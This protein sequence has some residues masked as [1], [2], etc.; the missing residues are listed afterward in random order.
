MFF[1]HFVTKSCIKEGKDVIF[2]KQ[3][4]RNT[5]Q[6]VSRDIFD[7]FEHFLPGERYIMIEHGFAHRKHVIFLILGRDSH[8]T[9]E[10]L[11]RALELQTA[12]FLVSKAFELFG[13]QIQTLIK[14]IGF[15]REVDIP[16][17]RIA[18]RYI[19]RFNRINKPLL[20]AQT[21]VQTRIDFRHLKYC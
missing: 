8:L 1:G 3:I 21:Q 4:G 14:V 18:E 11:N 13:C 6:S 9:V 16:V 19:L 2:C 15:A 20:L 10:L 5:L 7:T 17:T 12:Q